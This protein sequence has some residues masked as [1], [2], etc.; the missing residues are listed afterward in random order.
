MERLQSYR[1][2][3]TQGPSFFA[4]AEG[5]HN[6]HFGSSEAVQ[7]AFS[8]SQCQLGLLFSC[9]TLTLHWHG[10]GRGCAG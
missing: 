7:I 6:T 9:V 5:L 8:L 3:E 4:L 2:M 1:A 10:L